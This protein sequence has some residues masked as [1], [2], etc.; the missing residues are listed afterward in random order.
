MTGKA[1]T[2]RREDVLVIGGG[3]I[4]VCVAY[5]LTQ[6]GRQVTLVEKGEICSGCSSGNAGLIAP[7]HSI[8]LPAPGVLRKALKW[9]FD[10]ESPFYLKP[11]LDLDL[12]WWLWRFRAACK[13]T[14]MRRAM[15]ILRDLNHAS[16]ELYDELASDDDLR[17]A[18]EQKGLLEL[19]VTEQGAR[20]C[21]KAAELLQE[22]GIEL[23]L[24][25]AAQARAMAPNALPAVLGGVY[26]PGDV[27]IDPAEF[28]TQL[29]RL[30]ESRGARLRT[31]TEVLG[32]ETSARRVSA[33]VT[34]RGDFC[35]HHVVLAAGA[36]SAS[37]AKGL[38]IK[39]PVQP[40]KGYSITVTRPAKAPR[41]PLLLSEAKVAVTPFGETLRF[42]GTLEL[43]GLDLSIN[44]RRVAAIRRAV[45]KY[46]RCHEGGELIEIWRGL[47]PC[48]PDGLPVIGRSAAYED[49]IIATGHGMK[50]ICLAPITGNLVAQLVCD[51]EPL[52]DLTPLSPE[53]FH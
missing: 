3:V 50:G 40:A 52:L 16:K 24:L 29:A 11:R 41:V 23:N 4:G 47:R 37:L 38:G 34:T 48:T 19:F 9:M 26:S 27:H 14:R 53:R 51:E 25:D 5:Y 13:R 30:A 12:L 20:E 33:V 39:L 2:K 35:P 1:A 7:S 22:F 43:A 31:S 10:P 8:P 42:A 15:P 17:F 45:R 36:W 6:A 18:Y 49:L 32:F 44:R 21:T 28:T 46:H